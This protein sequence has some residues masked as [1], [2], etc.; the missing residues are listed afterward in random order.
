MYKTK[1]GV[2]S[3]K[4]ASKQ[5][6]TQ[7]NSD[8]GKSSQVSSDAL[9]KVQGYINSWLDYRK[10][11]MPNWER[12]TKLF[13]NIR[14]QKKYQG[15]SSTFV[16]MT[17]ST[18][19]TITAALVTGDMNTEFIPQDIYKYLSDNLEKGYTGTR[20][21]ANGVEAEETKEQFLVRAIK[22]ALKGG[23]IKDE[24]LEILNALYDYHW[25]SGDW[26]KLFSK[27]IKSG[28]K[29][30]N[31]AFWEV[32]ENGR[33]KLIYVP[34]VDFVFDP[35]CTDDDSGAFKGRRYFSS[36]SSM[37]SEVIVDPETGKKKK[38]YNLRG[39]TTSNIYDD[40]KTDKQLKEELLYGSTVSDQKGIDQVEVIELRCGTR[41]YVVINRSI[42][43]EDIENPIITQAKL[44]GIDTADLILYPCVT[45]ANY[46]DDSLYIGESETSTFWQEQERLNDTTNQKSDSVTRALLQNYRADPA[47]KAQ[48]NSFNVP[49]AVIWGTT[50]QYEAIPPAV[51]PGAAFNEEA[52]I[53]NNIREVTA[54]DQIVKGVGST[55]DITATEAQL[56]VAQSGQ[57]VEMKVDSLARGPLKRLARLTLQYYRLFLVDPFI[58]PKKSVSGIEPLLYDPKKYDYV[59]EPKVILNIAAQNKKR[60]EQREALEAYKMLIQ[61]PTNNLDEV[62]K[63]MLP[64]IVDLDRD[65][66]DRIIERNTMPG[67]PV[68]L[69]PTPS[70][71]TQAPDMGGQPA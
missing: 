43:A 68:T 30:G 42:I 12:D 47:L 39:V 66:I 45:W 13:N 16:P 17:R 65:E 53:K 40:D 35:T 44:R 59:Y 61:D 64:K 54:T 7:S 55:S 6:P 52:S 31:G 22:E 1:D 33:P 57:R 8:S 58:F 56:Q 36:L 46:E 21:D 27:F 5:Q 23:V 29:I 51:V 14:Y 11:L 50:G 71:Q 67:D 3:S 4:V 9:G 18:I 63:I 69:P 2:A 60:Q 24:S 26:D 38:R 10:K 32:W 34:F 70:L 28:L 37:K 20:K 62:K 25:D 15:V 41:Q 49:G 48:K 19:E